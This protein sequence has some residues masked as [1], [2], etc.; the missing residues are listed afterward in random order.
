[1]AED[2]ENKDGLRCIHARE[3]LAKIKV[4]D[5]V[6]YDHVRIIGNLG[7]LDLRKLDLHAEKVSRTK[8]QIKNLPEE[9]KV[10]YLSD[11][12]IITSIRTNESLFDAI[13]ELKQLDLPD[14]CLV[15]ES[16]IT[17]TNSKF[18]D[19]VNLDNFLFKGKL[20][21]KNTSFIY[22]NFKRAIFSNEVDFAGATFSEANFTGATF[23]KANFTGAKFLL[24]PRKFDSLSKDGTSY[25]RVYHG[26]FT[27]ATFKGGVLFTRAQF[28]DEADFTG[29]KFESDALFGNTMF[30]RYANF[31]ETKFKGVY[32]NR[33][34]FKEDTIF[35]GAMFRY[36]ADFTGATFKG[37]S[38]FV[39]AI[40]RGNAKFSRAEFEGNLLT[41]R[42]ST[43]NI[44][45]Y[46]E[47]ACRK[48]KNVLAKAGNRDEEGYHFFQEMKAK[49][50]QK[51]I[52][53]N[54]GHGLGDCLK[55]RPWSFWKFI[56]HDVLEYILIQI[57][58]R[59]GTSPPHLFIW[60]CAIVILFSV[61]YWFGDGIMG[62]TN[63]LDC[64][65]VSFAIAIAPG[66]FAAI[67]NPGSTGYRLISE[68]Q[69]VAMF[70]TI[71]G[72]FFW[73]GFI[74]TFARKYMR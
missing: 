54:S 25:R 68:Y 50:I 39:G 16:E 41:F 8:C 33:A 40:F 72:T 67:I 10:R 28:D 48:A 9:C 17:I 27:G 66:Y 21:F 59:Y 45:K 73:A 49:R 23:S 58:F 70:E 5:H 29:A 51:G 53:G 4:G 52:R 46:Q 13:D 57:I 63:L 11:S 43:F 22:A 44:A 18:E 69:I 6:A 24:V 56:K 55:T 60:W 30:S 19:P 1:M 65:K 20:I 74:A 15:I 47:V 35:C 64:I 37:N 61:L 2:P 31:S 32:F 71:I 12:S 62:I 3:I 34:T 7:N 38:T 14:E 36:E 42:N 26:L